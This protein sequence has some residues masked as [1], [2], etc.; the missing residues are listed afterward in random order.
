M[1]VQQELEVSKPTKRLR[2]EGMQGRAPSAASETEVEEMAT[3]ESAENAV[4][5]LK[6]SLKLLVPWNE[7]FLPK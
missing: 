3:E 6:S 1:E 4:K 5:R 2:D 7:L